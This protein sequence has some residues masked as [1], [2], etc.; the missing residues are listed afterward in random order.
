MLVPLVSLLCPGPSV[1]ELAPGFAVLGRPTWDAR[2]LL[3]QLELRLGM[4]RPSLSVLGSMDRHTMPASAHRGP[5]SMRW[6]RGSDSGYRQ[7]F[8]W[9]TSLS[10][11]LRA[12]QVSL[13]ASI[14]WAL[15]LA[16]S[17]RSRS[18]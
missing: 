10:L 14:F 16:R 2:V 9:Y 1:S 4:P 12:T 17:K 6:R 5:S 11:L 3:D 13:R 15:P 8:R 7:S 18:G